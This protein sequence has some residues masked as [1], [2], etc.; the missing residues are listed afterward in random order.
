MS[1]IK[2]QI[3]TDGERF[4]F[5]SIVKHQ[6]LFYIWYTC[7]WESFYPYSKSYEEA[8]KEIRRRYGDEAS[9]KWRPWRPA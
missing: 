4:R 7:R 1:N 2:Y 3:M 8:E 6:F 9:I 5:R